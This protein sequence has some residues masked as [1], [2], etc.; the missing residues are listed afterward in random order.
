MQLTLATCS[1]DYKC[2]IWK[3]RPTNILQSDSDGLPVFG[4]EVSWNDEK[5]SYLRGKPFENKIHYDHSSKVYT[6]NR[7][8]RKLF[9]DTLE[10]DENK[11]TNTHPSKKARFAAYPSSSPNQ[12][13]N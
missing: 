1:D 3:T 12:M 2:K 7:T 6:E 9:S 4:G 11:C 8:K 5:D 10:N 13:T